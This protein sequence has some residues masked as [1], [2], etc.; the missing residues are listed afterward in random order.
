MVQD[1]PTITTSAVRS[2][3]RKTVKRKTL[4]DNGP[5]VAPAEL[6]EIEKAIDAAVEQLEWEKVK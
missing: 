6:R 1:A 2:G 4:S 3:K 5:K